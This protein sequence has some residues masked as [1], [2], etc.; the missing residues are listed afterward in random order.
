MPCVDQVIKI[1][2][3]DAP[4]LTLKGVLMFLLH[5]E[6][7]EAG[8][9]ENAIGFYDRALRLNQND[10]YV[11]FNKATALSYLERPDDAIACLE[12]IIKIQPDDVQA[13]G[14]KGKQLEIT[15]R[16]EEA[17]LCYDKVVRSQ[18]RFPSM[19]YRKFQLL[20]RLGRTEE[21]NYF[22]NDLL[23]KHPEL[24]DAPE[25]SQIIK[26]EKYSKQYHS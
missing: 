26:D 14:Q 12:K 2:P 3:S 1:E 10:T 15:G 22:V 19:I 21:A 8:L 6:T 17:L 20:C 24:V 4:A 23:R 25:I 11:L 18:P 16:H 7:G 9:L 13:I 5:K